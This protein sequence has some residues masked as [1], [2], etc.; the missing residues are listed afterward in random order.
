[1]VPKMFPIV[2]RNP[3]IDLKKYT[4]LVHG[5]YIVDYEQIRLDDPTLYQRIL[6]DEREEERRAQEEY[7]AIERMRDQGLDS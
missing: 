7:E 5:R 6:D 2:G 4:V 1:M 3:E